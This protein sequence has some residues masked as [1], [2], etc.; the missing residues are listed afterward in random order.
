MSTLFL[1]NE[2]EAKAFTGKEPE[3]AFESDCQEMQYC[4]RKS[5]GKWFF[6]S[7]KGQKK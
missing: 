3:E 6:I 1:V 2:E 7:V 4:Y 5:R